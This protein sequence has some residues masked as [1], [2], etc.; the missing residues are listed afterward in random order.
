MT[1][2]KRSAGA[3]SG[4]CVSRVVRT[5]GDI[6]AKLSGRSHRVLVARGEKASALLTGCE[7]NLFMGEPLRGAHSQ[8]SAATTK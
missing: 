5:R 1:V 3:T 8:P 6:G 7:L 4:L 2:L